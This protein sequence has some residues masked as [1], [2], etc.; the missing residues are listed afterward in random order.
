MVALDVVGEV[1]VPEPLAVGE[2]GQAA[3]QLVLRAENVV[4]PRRGGSKD[5]PFAQVA[6]EGLLVL[7]SFVTC[8]S[9]KRGSVGPAVPE[10]PE[11]P[12]EAV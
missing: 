7:V 5:R 3:D 8:G 12:D 1:R 4:D 6:R 11:L 10:F 2:Q 9:V